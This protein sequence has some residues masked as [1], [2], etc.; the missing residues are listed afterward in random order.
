M[1][2]NKAN[3]RNSYS[4]VPTYST[5]NCPLFFFTMPLSL[6]SSPLGP[7]LVGHEF[8]F[9]FPTSR[10]TIRGHWSQLPRSINSFRTKGEIKMKQQIC[11][12]V[13]ANAYTSGLGPLLLLGLGCSC[14]QLNFK[15][16]TAECDVTRRIKMA[17]HFWPWRA[18]SLAHGFR[19]IH[20]DTRFIPHRELFSLPPFV[21]NTPMLPAVDPLLYKQNEMSYYILITV[22]YMICRYTVYL[23]GFV[24]KETNNW[25]MHTTCNWDIIQSKCRAREI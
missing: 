21:S 5:R 2:C 18:H 3:M 1:S 7:W 20:Q 4:C 9:G 16:H 17:A 19:Q 24:L 22:W 25:R 12:C 23:H 11:S 6:Y 8:L 10:N 15:R 14:F 13:S